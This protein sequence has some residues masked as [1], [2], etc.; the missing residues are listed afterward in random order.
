VPSI[1]LFRT[2]SQ[3]SFALLWAGQTVSRIGD[4]L[5]QVALAWWVLQKTGSAVAM[6]TV[7]IFSTLPMLAFLII[8]GVAVDRMSRIGV[9]LGSDLA[10]G[11]TVAL[12]AGL[13]LTNHLEIWQVYLAS[14]LFGL[15][16]AF[17]QPAYTALVPSIVPAKDLTSANS[18]TSLS[19]QTGRIVG[20]ALAAAVVALA[21][22]A[23]AFAVNALT[24]FISTAFLIPLLGLAVARR[25]TS[26]QDE[27]PASILADAREGIA[28][29]L[30][31]PWLWLTITLFALTNV[32]LSGPYSVALPFLVRDVRHADVGDLGLLYAVFPVGYVLGSIWLGGT[33]TIRQRGLVLYGGVVVA[34][35]MLVPFGLPIPLGV[36]VAAAL[37]NGAALEAST[38]AWTNLLQERVPPNKLGRVSSI[39]MLGSYALLPIGYAV[40]G[41]ATEL[42]GPALVFI[43]GGGLTAV[44]ATVALARPLIR[45][46]D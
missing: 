15:V 7:L 29:V 17:F 21:G 33:T 24:F 12:V 2:L 27:H 30:A 22:P 20:P 26:S 19:T 9:M 45:K 14:L 11:I 18:L 34:G 23:T 6:G 41:W 3:R 35:L 36:L 46:L 31:A 10:R 44:F 32:T 43:V 5:Y 8:G 28:T 37:I 42:I 1:A 4:S 40:T 38:L 16:D 25:P 39:D 13:A